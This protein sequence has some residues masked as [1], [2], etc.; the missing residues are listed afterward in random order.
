MAKL[1]RSSARTV[2]LTSNVGI[3]GLM[4]FQDEIQLHN[5]VIIHDYL[6]MLGCHVHADR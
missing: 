5:L 6:D 2:G 4:T 1:K 3:L